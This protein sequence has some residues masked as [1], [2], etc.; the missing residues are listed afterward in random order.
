MK[1]A[2]RYPW[3]RGNTN[4]TLAIIISLTYDKIVKKLPPLAAIRAFEAAARHG[5]YTRAGEELGLSQAG[6]SYQI[7]ALEERVGEVLFVRRGRT[8]ELTAAAAELA[9]RITEAFSMME[10]AF[11][12]LERSE[13]SVL[14]I[15]CFETFATKVLAPHLGAFHI[16]H[17]EIAVRLVVSDEYVDL[18]AGRCDLA[19]R[20]SREAPDKMRSHT[21]S[22]LVIAPFASPEVAARIVDTSVPVD[23]RISP[24]FVWWNDWDRAMASPA[25]AD[26]TPS[27]F[28]GLQFD[29]QMLSAAAAM[30]GN[31]VAILA[32]ILFRA[33]LEAGRLV[34][35][36]SQA[37]HTDRAFRMI[38][39]EIR[40]NAP[41]I[42][43]FRAWFDRE[44]GPLLV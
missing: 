24:N 43:A 17:P 33:E 7:R 8:M 1:M 11:A 20:V 5:N 39:P 2:F 25:S 27:S 12:A 35:V 44:L 42:K 31:G 4:Q 14:T 28:R 38:Y 21:L 36:G 29:S 19:I 32:P 16:A 22:P 37:A 18:E 30:S 40:R 15:A 9:S 3:L 23:Q 34:R 10:G 6:V 26:A 41:K 13:D